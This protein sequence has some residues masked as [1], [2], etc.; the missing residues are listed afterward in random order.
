[1]HPCTQVLLPFPPV[2]Q[3]S[4]KPP[5]QPTLQPTLH[6]PSPSLTLSNV[7]PNPS[8]FITTPACPIGKTGNVS[9]VRYTAWSIPT[10]ASTSPLEISVSSPS[11]R[12]VS[13]SNAVLLRDATC[14]PASKARRARKRARS[15]WVLSRPSLRMMRSFRAR[16][17]SW[18]ASGER[19]LKTRRRIFSS[20]DL[21]IILSDAWRGRLE[22]DICSRR[23]SD[24]M[25]LNRVTR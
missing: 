3:L 16:V 24:V 7:S 25:L 17:D 18:K 8:S 5:T 9:P 19:V 21:Q 1:M 6:P 20:V 13:A 14:P 23:A 11:L 2:L 22:S 15:M 4:P 12:H 10:N